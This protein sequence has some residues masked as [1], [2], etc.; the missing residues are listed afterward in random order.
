MLKLNWRAAAFAVALQISA[1]GFAATWTGASGFPNPANDNWNNPGN[2]SGNVVPSPSFGT[3]LFFG[4]SFRTTPFQNLADPFAVGSLNFSLASYSLSGFP[5]AFSSGAIHQ[6]SPGLTIANNLSVNSSLTYDGFGDATFSG[7]L[8][9]SGGLTKNGP[10][11]LTLNSNNT[12]TGTTEINQGQVALG[13]P[14][15]LATST[16]V[17]N[18]NNGLNLKN[19]EFPRIG[20]LSGSG[21][22]YL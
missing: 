16:V 6:N 1:T 21:S 4:Q 11:T 12:F 5:I 15:V 14:D 18:T 10:G 22:L 9:G 8:S 2:W 3:D 7:V 20:G 13:N 17:I 19:H